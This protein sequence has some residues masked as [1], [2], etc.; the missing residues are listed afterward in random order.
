MSRGW[1]SAEAALAALYDN[2]T[3]VSDVVAAYITVRIRAPVYNVLISA[4]TTKSNCVLIV[5]GLSAV[6]HPLA[7]VALAACS[8]ACPQQHSKLHMDSTMHAYAAAARAL[9]ATYLAHDAARSTEVDLM[10]LQ[11]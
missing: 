7:V 6:D 10:T 9:C 8:L 2:I 1:L 4:S 5:V 3:V 11:M